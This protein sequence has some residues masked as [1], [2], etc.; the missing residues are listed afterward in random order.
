MAQ[1]LGDLRDGRTAPDHLG[2]QAVSEEVCDA[3]RSGTYACAPKRQAHNV[4]DRTRT[5][6]PDVGRNQAQKHASRCA[7]ATT[8]LKVSRDGGTNV[9]DQRDMI[10]LRP[11]A[12]DHDFSRTPA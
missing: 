10:Q 12:A 9:D 1:H 2:S 11:F 8:V 4:I 7:G 5:R 6:K 3:P